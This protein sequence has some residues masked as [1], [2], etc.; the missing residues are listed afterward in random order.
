MSAIDTGT[1]TAIGSLV[2]G[3]ISFAVQ[4]TLLV[5]ALTTVKRSR[6][7]AAM[8]I[9][10]SAAVHLFTNIGGRVLMAAVPYMLSASSVSGIGASYALVS[11]VMTLFNAVGWALLIVGIVKLASPLPGEGRVDPTRF[12]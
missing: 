9:A 11:L 5:I 12:Q 8:L 6:P 3:A 4:L 2:G 10:G 7:D 1:W